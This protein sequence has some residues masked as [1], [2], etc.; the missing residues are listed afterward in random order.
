MN[1]APRASWVQVTN[2][3]VERCMTTERIMNGDVILSNMQ[4]MESPMIAE[5]VI[6]MTLALARSLPQFIKAMS[7]VRG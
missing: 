4:K 7:P 3:G 1:A 5:H 6:A 2:A